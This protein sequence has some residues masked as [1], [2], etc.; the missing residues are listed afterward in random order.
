MI[1]QL[2]SSLEKTVALADKYSKSYSS[3]DIALT[4]DTIT[5]DAELTKRQIICYRQRSDTFQPAHFYG[6][7]EDVLVLE[8]RDSTPKLIAV[9]REQCR[10]P[11]T[12]FLDPVLM[13]AGEP[14][15]ETEN[16]Q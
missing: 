3:F 10:Y 13:E 11:N 14:Q 15:A 12:D 7:V 4:G 6:A 8:T 16:D 9:K 5:P 1:T 2:D